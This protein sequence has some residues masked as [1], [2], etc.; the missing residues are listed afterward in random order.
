AAVLAVP[1]TAPTGLKSTAEVRSV[2]LEWSEP[3]SDG[4]APVLRYEYR[5]GRAS[6]SFA[7]AWTPVGNV[8]STT[9]SGLTAGATYY[10][11]VRAVNS[12][13]DG[14]ADEVA[15]TLNAA[16]TIAGLAS[17]VYEENVVVVVVGT[18]TAS[19]GD[20]GDTVTLS[21]TGGADADLFTLAGDEL[22]FRAPPDYENPRDAGGERNVYVVVLT[23]TDDG[24]PPLSGRLEV[25]VAV[26]N[27]EEAGTVKITAGV[28]RV[29]DTLTAILTDP[30]GVVVITSWQWQSAAGGDY[31][32]IAVGTAAAY[33]LRPSD[34][35]KTLR[36]TATYND[37]ED[38]GKTATSAPTAAALAVPPTAPTGLEATLGD[39]SAALAWSAPDSDGGAPVDRYEYRQRTSSGVFAGDWVDVGNATAA[40]VS[41]LTGGETYYFEVRAVNS[42]DGGATATVGPLTINTAPTVAGLAAPVHAENRSGGIVGPYSA[43]DGDAGDAVTLAIVGGA[44]ADLFSIAGGGLLRFISPPDYEHPGDDGADNVYDVVLTATDDGLPPL[45]GRLE[46][47]VRVTDVEEIGIVAITV[48][49]SGAPRIGG[50]LTATLADPDGGVTGIT[51]QWSAK[52]AAGGGYVDIADAAG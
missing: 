15:V 22:A 26:T 44:D 11:E 28:P 43:S 29:G 49:P 25:E 36:A 31:A 30:D 6:G 13:G 42:A 33:M 39:G 45:T 2:L 12:A 52:P 21:I 8:T 27:V 17:V 37:R 46:V 40:T 9:V 1:P 50:V 23:A 10:V 16:P 47:T 51:W 4:G 24:V 20:D 41:D 7:G 48:M 5:V 14:E 38:S 32:D 19:D 18:Y 34:A 3:D 35:G